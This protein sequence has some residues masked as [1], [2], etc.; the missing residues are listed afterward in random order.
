MPLLPCGSIS[1]LG[2]VLGCLSGHVSG[3]SA[4]LPFPPLEHGMEN[5]REYTGGKEEAQ[6]S[7][8]PCDHVK[9]TCGEGE[10][11]AGS[12]YGSQDLSF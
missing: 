10:R 5:E 8:W 4:E 11:G 3:S 9:Q 6:G 7:F 12:K 1:F 2:W